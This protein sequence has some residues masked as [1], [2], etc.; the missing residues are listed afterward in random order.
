MQRKLHPTAHPAL[1][2]ATDNL[3]FALQGPASRRRRS[4][5]AGLR[6]R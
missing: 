3:A 5:C 2:Q 6:S 1:A 4:R